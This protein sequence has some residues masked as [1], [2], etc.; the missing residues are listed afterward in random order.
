MHSCANKCVVPGV[1]TVL[2]IRRKKKINPQD[3]GA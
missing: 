2:K 3:R 1:H